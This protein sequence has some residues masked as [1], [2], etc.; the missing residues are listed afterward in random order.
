M[1]SLCYPEASHV[2]FCSVRIQ[3]GIEL[4]YYQNSDFRAFYHPRGQDWPKMHR[5]NGSFDDV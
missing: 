3:P 1:V 2:L 4:L 5:G